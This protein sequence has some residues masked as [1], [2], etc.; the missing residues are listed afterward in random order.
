[1]EGVSE[2]NLFLGGEVG[3]RGI[4]DASGEII[5]H[6]W[7]AVPM[8]CDFKEGEPQFSKMGDIG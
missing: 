6:P 3:C 4:E 7:E 2:F 8:G 1:M 5:D